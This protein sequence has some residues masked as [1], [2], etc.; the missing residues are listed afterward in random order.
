M[1][2]QTV[3]QTVRQTNQHNDRQENIHRHIERLKKTQIVRQIHTRIN[4]RT[5]RLTDR[6]IDGQMNKRKWKG[7]DGQSD[8]RTDSRTDRQT[9]QSQEYRVFS[10]LYIMAT[11]EQQLFI[12]IPLSL[13]TSV[14]GQI[15]AI[16]YIP[17]Q[18][19]NVQ[20]R[21]VL[22]KCLFDTYALN[23]VYLSATDV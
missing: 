17:G 4:G 23:Q 18:T 20:T 2:I 22:E 3:R 12:S 16:Q 5:D 9:C 6:Q 13:S 10:H 11:K 8:R 19:F 21:K 14:T 7:T 15:Q 1:D